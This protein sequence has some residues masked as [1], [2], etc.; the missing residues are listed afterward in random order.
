MPFKNHSKGFVVDG[1]QALMTTGAFV[2]KTADRVEMVARFQGDA[3]KALRELIDAGM[4]G[5]ADRLRAAA[6]NAARYG[7]VVNEPVAGVQHLTGAVHDMI[8]GAK[9]DIV[10]S[11][12]IFTD[13]TVR[14]AVKD[15]EKR[16]VRVR[17]VW[18]MTVGGET[19][20]TQNG[21]MPPRVMAD[22]YWRPEFGS[23]TVARAKIRCPCGSGRKYKKCC[24]RDP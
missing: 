22:W 19:S 11:T 7:I 6:D 16:G 13:P 14:A 18:P 17:T 24:M 12:K 21:A 1:D 15:A 3:A 4:A 8:R 2:P 23:T 9:K 20:V 10:I 5:K